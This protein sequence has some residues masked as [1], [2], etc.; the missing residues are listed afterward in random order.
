MLVSVTPCSVLPL[1]LPG[2]HGE[3]RVP[4][5]CVE[6]LPVPPG[7]AVVV[8]DD[9]DDGRL[10][11]QAEANTARPATTTNPMNVRLRC[12]TAPLLIGAS[13]LDAA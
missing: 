3:A 8:F 13:G 12:A 9:E 1:A 11:L 10:L 6:E 7:E 4:N 2:P 5:V